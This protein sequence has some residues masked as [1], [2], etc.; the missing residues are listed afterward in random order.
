MI[1]KTEPI[2]R[3]AKEADTSFVAEMLILTLQTQPELARR[4]IQDLTALV[5]FEMSGWHRTYNYP[6]VAWLGKERVGAVWLSEG[7]EVGGKTFTLGLAVVAAYRG[8]GIGSR[9]MEYAQTFCLKQKATF[10]F[11]K[12]HPTNETA[13]RLYRRFGFEPGMLEMKKR[14]QS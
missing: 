9:L 11:L 2:I 6:F 13:L 7:G 3:P 10:I 5:R 14:L 1:N 12:V 4:S 8:Q